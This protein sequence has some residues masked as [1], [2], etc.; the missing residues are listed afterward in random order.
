M[1]Y[2]CT[3]KMASHEWSATTSM[4]KIARDWFASMPSEATLSGPLLASLAP[5]AGCILCCMSMARGHANTP[6]SYCFSDVS[7]S[8]Y[9]NSPRADK[10]EKK[11][12]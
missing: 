2:N 9:K 3:I 8:P 4:E 6:N 1:I 10:R 11:E 7:L 5:S 12:T